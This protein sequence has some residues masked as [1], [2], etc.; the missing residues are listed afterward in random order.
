MI[1]GTRDMDSTTN[2]AELAVQRQLEAYNARDIDAFMQWWAEDC[3][4]YAF[5]DTL[6]AQG[7]DAIRQ[8]HLDR[9]TEPDLFGTLVT[10]MSAG[11]VVIDR[12]VVTRTFPEGPG[13]VD[14]IAI[15]EVENGKIARAWFKSGTP[16]LFG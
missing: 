9:F 2:P 15:Y 10:R 3:R 4:Y 12:E 16:R 1:F 11:N 5:P 14:V 7:A 8:R 13:E 6:L